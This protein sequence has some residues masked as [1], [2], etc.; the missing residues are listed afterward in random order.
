M[1]WH[2]WVL[3]IPPGIGLLAK[4]QVYFFGGS[5]RKFSVFTL[6]ST[7]STSQGEKVESPGI[8][9][10][11]FPGL[12]SSGKWVIFLGRSW[13]V[14]KICKFKWKFSAD[15]KKEPTSFPGSTPL[16]R[17][18]WEAPSRHLESGVDPGNEVEKERS[19]NIL[20]WVE[21]ILSKCNTV[22]FWRT[23]SLN[24]HLES[25]KVLENCC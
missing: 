18:R 23:N 1:A 11:H 15:M 20:N 6:V 9:F 10:W 7:L 22:A 2:L 8:L 4:S 16:S 13:K 19:Q 21:E 25:G 3:L 17:W 12:E 24:V 14:L 5:F